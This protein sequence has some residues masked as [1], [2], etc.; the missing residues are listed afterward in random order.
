MLTVEDIAVVPARV[1]VP[2]YLLA[3][4]A[5]YW[6]NHSPMTDAAYDFM[7]KRLGAEYDNFEHPH[8][9]L[10]DRESMVAGT[11]LLPAKDYPLI[12]RSSWEQFYAH[13]VSGWMSAHIQF[14]YAGRIPSAPAPVPAPA[15]TSPSVSARPRPIRRSR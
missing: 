1:L 13:C 2:Y 12:V 11:C 15:P 9:H 6:Q 8:K 5:Y 14:L 4:F 3:S 10:V 7:C